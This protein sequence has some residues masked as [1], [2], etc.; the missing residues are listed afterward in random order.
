MCASVPSF[1]GDVLHF[2]ASVGLRCV[3]PMKDPCLK[4]HKSIRRF[5]EAFL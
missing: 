4:S 2:R 3:Y 5:G 1:A